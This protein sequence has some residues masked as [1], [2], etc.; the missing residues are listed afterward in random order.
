LKETLPDIE[1]QIVAF[2]PKYEKAFRDLN[3][4][5]ISHY[6][7]M[8]A[9]D[10]KALDDPQSSILGNGGHILVALCNNEVAGVCALLKMND[11]K[12]QYELAKMAVAPEMQGKNIG[13]LLGKA[14]AQKASALGASYIYL[15]TNAVLTPATALY[16]K[17]GFEYVYGR[18][19]PYERCN[20]QMELDLHASI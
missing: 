10:Y 1:V 15:E 2:E 17:L 8:E 20:V 16:K 9:S 14:I 12:Y 18:P 5:W 7:K 11:E 6:F 13:F 19:T 3:V 4:A